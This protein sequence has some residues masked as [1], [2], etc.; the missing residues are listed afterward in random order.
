VKEAK[1]EIMKEEINKE[2]ED[3]TKED[4][5]DASCSGG[6]QERV[7]YSLYISCYLVMHYRYQLDGLTRGIRYRHMSED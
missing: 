7:N 1:E 2:G 3:A 5:S 6:V 4:K